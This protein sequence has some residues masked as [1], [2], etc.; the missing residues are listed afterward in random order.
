MLTAGIKIRPFG[1]LSYDYC[2]LM[3]QND[4]SWSPED[5]PWRKTTRHEQKK[6]ADYTAPLLAIKSD[7]IKKGRP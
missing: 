1:S 2:Q 7:E 3:T 6:G 4:T 5:I